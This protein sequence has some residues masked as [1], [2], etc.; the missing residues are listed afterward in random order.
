MKTPTNRRSFLRSASLGAAAVVAASPAA[1]AAVAAPRSKFAAYY[2]PQWMRTKDCTMEYCLAMPEETYH[3]KPTEEVRSFADQM[4]H[5]AGSS[6]FFASNYLGGSNP[7]EGDY[8]PDG[9]SKQE[10]ADLLAESFD[11]CAEV[12]GGLSDDDL[13]VE[14]ETFAGVLPRNEVVIFM[15]D[16]VTHHRGQTVV[17]LRLNGIVPPAYVG[18]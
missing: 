17:Y 11:Y 18:A 5:I 1:V 8:T 16:H 2:L 4:L 13:H 14:V 7:P 3:F 6:I 15:R 12:I 10:C 9:K